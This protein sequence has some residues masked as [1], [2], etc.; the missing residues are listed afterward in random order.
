VLE[1]GDFFGEL[2]LLEDQRRDAAARAATPYRLLRID[3]TTL[4]QLVQENPEI[5]VRML[6]RLASRLR[7]H[8]EARL[9][10]SE[11]AA[12]AMGPL[13]SPR[14][15]QAPPP[16]TADHAPKSTG[17]RESPAPQPAA[18]PVAVAAPR[19][20]SLVH[21]ATGQQFPLSD[22]GE[23]FVGRADRASG[24]TPGIDL[25]PVDDKR[26]L[27]RRHAKIAERDGK[28]YVWEE[29]ATR[30]G[31]FVNGSR[32]STGSEV[33]LKDGDKVRFGLVETIFRYK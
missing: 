14:A 26:T 7:E 24:F 32:I 31:T 22:R 8:E 1:C 28:F 27:S 11:I 4:H 2:S 12:A 29:T 30:N 15:P 20:A 17:A 5:A 23:L 21:S 9:R 25:T 19:V 6:H 13:P 16:P 3:R 33:E 18:A 10:A